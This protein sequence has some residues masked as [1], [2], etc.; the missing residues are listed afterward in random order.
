MEGGMTTHTPAIHATVHNKIDVEARPIANFHPSVWSDYFL[1]YVS[2]DKETK[3]LKAKQLEELKEEVRKELLA[4]ADKSFELL[5]FIDAIQRLGVAYHFEVEIEDA[6]QRIYDN[7]KNVDFDLYYTSLQFRL[8]RQ[9]GFFIPYDVFNKFIDERE[10]FSE[11]IGS[12]IRGILS[13]YEAAHVRTQADLTLDKALE[14]TT[15]FLKSIDAT[16]LSQP[17]AGQALHA[18]EQPLHKGMT[19]LESRHYITFYEQDASH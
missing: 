3:A 6:L 8:L 17:L 5:D 2:D 14:F 18:L 19:R 1:N 15:A 9:H 11:C 4:V 13:L 7:Y 12:D 10:N 16:Q